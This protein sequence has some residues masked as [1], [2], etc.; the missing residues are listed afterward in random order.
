MEF[1]VPAGNIISIPPFWWNSIKFEYETVIVGYNYFSLIN[2]IS[3]INNFGRY[4][5]Q[6][7]NTI[8]NFF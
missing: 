8:F 5:L 2:K 4:Y 7:Q 6:Q 1:N 3:N